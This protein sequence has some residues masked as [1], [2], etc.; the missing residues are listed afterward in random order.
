MKQLTR[1]LT[2]LATIL[3]LFQ[4]AGCSKSSKATA[5]KARFAF[6]INVAGR[7]WDI[8]HA[9]CLQAAQEEGVEVEFYVPGESTAAQ[10]KQI[11]E[12]LISRDI[13]GLAITPLNPDSLARVLDEAGKYMPVICMDSDAPRSHRLCYIGTDNVAAGRAM[14]DAL[15]KARPEGGKAAIFVGQLD[16][17]NARERQQ[18][19]LEALA[20]TKWKVVGTFTDG[21]D[22]PTAKSNAADVMS[23]YPDLKG[24]VGLWGY[25]GF[26]AAKALEDNPGREVKIIAADEDVETMEAIRQGKIFAS[27]VQQPYEFGYQSIKM[28]ARLRRKDPVQIPA[29]KLIYV[30][31]KVMT[32]DNVTE[33]ETYVNEKLALRRRLLTQ[34][35]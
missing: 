6:V 31:I 12:A 25:N 2:L 29:D 8:A 16:V 20:G 23:K 4:V 24:I 33:I 7:F 1:L 17:G 19:A 13:D 27:I 30:P 21:A 34:S 11:I 14:G 15:K 32:R 18:G 26:C 10:Q 3:I 5:K 9:G 22:R 28:L 35:R